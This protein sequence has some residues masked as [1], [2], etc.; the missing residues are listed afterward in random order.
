MKKIIY[1]SFLIGMTVLVCSCAS[2]SDVPI[3]TK[4]ET[5]DWCVRMYTLSKNGITYRFVTVQSSTGE[6]GAKK[7]AMALHPNLK[8]RSAQKGKCKN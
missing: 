4:N 8:Y 3:I 2:T 6:A 5:E 1:S 7:Q